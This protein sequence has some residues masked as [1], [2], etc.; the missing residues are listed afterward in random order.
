M[1]FTSKVFAIVLITT[2]TFAYGLYEN[3]RIEALDSTGKLVLQE[4]PDINLA[5]VA[6]TTTFTKSNLIEADTRGLMVHFWGTWCAP[7]EAELPGFIKLA[8][9]LQVLGVKFLLIAVNDDVKKIKKFMKRFKTLPENVYLANDPSGETMPMF[10][11]AKVPET[12]LFSRTGKHLNKFVG[13]QEWEMATY[14][15]RIRR[16]VDDSLAG[17]DKAVETH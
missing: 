3:S 1:T 13:P 9:R 6:G 14:F 12:Y 2:L 4:M 16:L 5:D 17:R 10:G 8:D 15:D 11:T 7:C